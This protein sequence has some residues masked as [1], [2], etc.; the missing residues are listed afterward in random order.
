MKIAFPTDDGKTISAHFGRAPFFLVADIQNDN[1]VTYERREKAYHGSQMEHDQ[2]HEG[3]E[4]HSAMH[5][6][7]FGV[8]ADCQILI[9][10]GMGQ[11]A[12]EHA[13]EAGKNVILTGEKDIQS[14]VKLFQENKLASDPRRIHIHR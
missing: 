5:Q 7:M 6:G 11:P 3:G 14:A 2:H 9:A 8:I 12:Y 4:G 1:S 10:G 13:Q